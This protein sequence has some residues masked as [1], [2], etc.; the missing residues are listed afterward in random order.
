MT[1]SVNYFEDQYLLD[2]SP[3]GCGSRNSVLWSMCP[4]LI[5]FLC[6]SCNCVKKKN[7]NDDTFRH[8]QTVNPKLIFFIFDFIQTNVKQFFYYQTLCFEE[9]YWLYHRWCLKRSYKNNVWFLQAKKIKMKIQQEEIRRRITCLT[10]N[11]DLTW[12]E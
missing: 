4:Y 5:N 1:L 3:F 8:T 2:P 11:I 9:K 7:E 10:S 12:I 6:I